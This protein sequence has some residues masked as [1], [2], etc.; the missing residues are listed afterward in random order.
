MPHITTSMQRSVR[1][2]VGELLF[3]SL[4]GKRDIAGKV[5]DFKD[6]FS[7]WDKCMQA[8][9]CKWPV[10]AAIIVV[11]LILLSILTCIGRVCCCGA[12]CCCT[13]FSFL[14]CCDC[15]G[16]DSCAGKKDKPM[17]H[18]DNPFQSD[19]QGYQ[20]YQAPA[21]MMGG[22]LHNAGQ[23]MNVAAPQAPVPQYAQFEVGKNGLYVEPKVVPLNEDALP[24]MPS[25]EAAQKKHIAADEEKNAVELRELDPST[26][27]KMP[28]MAGAAG[29]GMSMPPSPD[30]GQGPSPFAVRPGTAGNGYMGDNQSQNQAAFNGNSRYGS[31]AP[32]PGQ[33]GYGA[34]TPQAYDGQARGYGQDIPYGADDGYGTEARGYGAPAPQGQY[35]QNNGFDAAAVGGYGGRQ[36]QGQYP[37]DGRPFPPPNRQYSNDSSRPMGPPRQYTDRSYGSD[38]MQA[39]GA[40][41]RGPSRGPGPNG[42]PR[43]PS[44]GPVPND[45]YGPPRGPSR[46]PPLRT[47][48]PALNNNSGF[49]FG[50]GAPSY[51]S[52]QS[53]PV[54]QGYGRPP[55][56][57]GNS[58]YFDNASIA[59]SYSS[60]PQDQGYP[61]YKAYQPGNP[62]RGFPQALSPGD[63][64]GREPQRWDPVHQ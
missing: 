25:W 47:G 21:P 60:T 38:N 8:S 42:P 17:K 64:R 1:R 53:P 63:G 52:Q 34:R 2:S 12:S 35:A 54:Q 57:T 15:C 9:Y 56:P 5:N 28:L 6:S 36:P 37:S 20:G 16:G 59:P 32:G 46:G 43:G 58:G 30:V 14:K 7:S 61:G 24:P 27:Q 18:K 29:N 49:D 22:A 51:Q 40:I 11:G 13:C 62:D 19:P 55:L 33:G 3:D 48:S 4:V 41:P 31:P 45:Q 44:R 26:G 10:I 23:P 50:G 39:G